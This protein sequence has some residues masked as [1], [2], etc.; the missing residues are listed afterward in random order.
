MPPLRE[1]G[2][3]INLLFRKFATDFA[4]KYR[5]PVVRLDPGAKHILENHYW[6]GN[7]RQLKNITEL[8]SILETTRNITVEVL[9]S[10][11]PS[12]TENKL[13][14]LANS[15]SAENLTEREMLYKVLIDMRAEVDL[16]KNAIHSLAQGQ[17]IS[18]AGFETSSDTDLFKP[19]TQELTV[20]TPNQPLT[21]VEF[22][23]YPPTQF[24]QAVEVEESLSLEEKEKELIQKALEK[25]RGKR[26]YAAQ[27]LGIS[28]R[29][30]YRKIKEY[31]L[32]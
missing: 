9:L 31:D 24:Q 11:L 19:T 13:P 8:I 6:P 26:K 17:S 10:Y 4:E 30:L 21:P 14:V 22:Q 29:T 23:Q 2:D 16:L 28:E 12:Y 7:V 18:A 1:R 3:D 32:N 5:M 27:D 20:T 25:H 15:E